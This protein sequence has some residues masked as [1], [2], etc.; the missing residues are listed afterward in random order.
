M[1]VDHGTARTVARVEPGDP[2]GFPGREQLGVLQLEIG[3]RHGRRGGRHDRDSGHG[4]P[5]SKAGIPP[6]G[7]GGGVVRA[8]YQPRNWPCKIQEAASPA[9]TARPAAAARRRRAG[10]PA[11]QRRPRTV[12]RRASPVTTY[13]DP[14]S[15][16]VTSAMPIASTATAA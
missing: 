15:D 12:S 4:E 10:R 8:G 13:S 1:V 6:G 16:K 5:P 14:A 7:P 3:G 9:R 2:E 11:D